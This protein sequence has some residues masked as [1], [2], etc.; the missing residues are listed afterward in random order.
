MDYS[1]HIRNGL[2]YM[3]MRPPS[4]DEYEAYNHVVLTSDVTWDPTVLDNEM[5]LNVPNDNLIV[6]IEEEY[7]DARSLDIREKG[8]QHII[9]EM[10][11][12]RHERDASLSLN[13]LDHEDTL[14]FLAS[15]KYFDAYKH[16][17]KRMEP[18]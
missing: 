10:L 1:L 17:T 5:D 15:E 8:T 3:D 18:D 11:W 12:D 4:Q 2:A 13:V 7:Y 6:N 14:D 16:E 9:A